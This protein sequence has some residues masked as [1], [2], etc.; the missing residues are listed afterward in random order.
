MKA[1]K[2]ETNSTNINSLLNTARTLTE[3]RRA[4]EQEP[5]KMTRVGTYLLGNEKYTELSNRCVEIG[6]FLKETLKV[7]FVLTVNLAAIPVAIVLILL[8][9]GVEPKTIIE[10]IVQKL[11][12]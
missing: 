8:L 5:S 11:L 7:L 12:G 10:F 4:A 9:A 1:T 3:K 2:V 6:Q